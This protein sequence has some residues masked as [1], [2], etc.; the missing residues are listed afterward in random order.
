MYIQQSSTKIKSIGT[1]AFSF[2]TKTFQVIKNGGY[3]GIVTFW[4]ASLFA[5]TLKNND[6]TE[7]N[8][9]K[10]CTFFCK[11]TIAKTRFKSTSKMSH[12]YAISLLFR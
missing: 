6:W 4:R 5:D 11:I 10:I 7:K 3:V 1:C 2:K 12:V 9:S 8:M